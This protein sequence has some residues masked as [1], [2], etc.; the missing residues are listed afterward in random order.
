[1]ST[2]EP[3]PSR[4]MPILWASFLGAV[5]GGAGVAYF[6]VKRIYND[7][8]GPG[9]LVH[10]EPDA[11]TPSPELRAAFDEKVIQ[12]YEALE[13]NGMDHLQIIRLHAP[14]KAPDAP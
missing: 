1:M 11:R 9:V 13:K 8:M 4:V 7:F 10:F 2:P 14:E 6:G 5:A 3:R 12:A